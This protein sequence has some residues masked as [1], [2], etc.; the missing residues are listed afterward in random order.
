L[1]IILAV[2]GLVSTALLAPGP[3]NAAGTTA[4]HR[5]AVSAG[6]FTT[7]KAPRQTHS[8]SADIRISKSI[9]RGYLQFKPKVDVASVTRAELVVTA[10]KVTGVRRITVRVASV[11]SLA[12]LTT[13]SKPKV[14]KIVGTSPLVKSGK[15]VTIRLKPSAIRANLVFALNL[16]KK[17]SAH[18]YKTGAKAPVL[19]LTTSTQPTTSTVVPP[20]TQSRTTIRSSRPNTTGKLVFAHYF[21]PYPISMDNADPSADY[22]AR[23]YLVASGENGKFAS[24]G[25]LL[26]D[27]PLTQAPVAGDFESANLRTEVRQAMSAGIDGFAVDILSL[28]GSNWDRTVKLMT[29][30][31]EVSS[32]FRIMLQPDM[33][34]STGSASQST[35]AAAVAKL[36][37]QPSAYRLADGR[38]VLSPFSAEKKSPSWWKE[39]ISI[40]S[41]TYGIKTAFLPLFLNANKMSDYA[42]VS[43]GFGNWGVRDPVAIAAAPNWASKAH[44][45]GRVWMQ[46]VAVQDVRPNQAIYD[47]AGNTEA[48]RASWD[49]AIADDADFVLMVT[50]NDYSENTSFAPSVNHGYCFLDISSS[51]IEKL[52]TGAF[53]D[54]SD[55]LYITHRV[56]PYSA[57][58]PQ[59]RLSVQRAASARLDLRDTVE[60]LTILK[61]PGTVT[62]KIG[63]STQSYAAPAGWFAKTFP[64]KTGYST[65]K[66]T[67]SGS[68]VLSVTTKDP[69]TT[70]PANQDMSY[71]A[72][73][74]SGR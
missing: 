68:T 43:Y 14:S 40:L 21:P 71:H 56:Q 67:R 24:V 27:R 9:Y 34:S 70:S 64:L 41:S 6:T 66:L 37:V 53:P 7:S 58:P 61:S 59:T 20:T 55:Q 1:A 51:Y 28:S 63:T 12:K 48:L 35:L 17:G 36:A 30:A 25:G 26:R 11:T 54:G 8:E 44:A 46:P 15:T 32:S 47:E 4:K 5:V 18:V 2:A 23:N 3:A 10:K 39:V 49:R 13:S 42:S 45:L 22:Y 52:K 74:A 16:S 19:R 31:S 29:A 50:W 33:T 60:V 72:V 69:V 62:I 38:V 57:E 65:A 73:G